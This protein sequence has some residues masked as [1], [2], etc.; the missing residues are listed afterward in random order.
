MDV[1]WLILL[2]F[3]HKY[4][5]K[6][7]E[8][9]DH[10]FDLKRWHRSSNVV[11]KELAAKELNAHPRIRKYAD[12]S[13][14]ESTFTIEPYADYLNKTP[15]QDYMMV[16]PYPAEQITKSNRWSVYSKANSQRRS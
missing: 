9:T 10:L 3:L 11:I 12:R 6:A 8:Y 1:V 2:P 14:P 16:F 13:N 4:R 5:K 15:Y 7:F